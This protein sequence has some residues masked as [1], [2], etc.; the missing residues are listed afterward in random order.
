[1]ASPPDRTTQ[2][3]VAMVGNRAADGTDTATDQCA[4]ERAAAGDGADR[5]AS[6]G[7]EQAARG[8]AVAVL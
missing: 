8:G 4:D 6:A 1:M 7:T 3:D 2:I 5:R